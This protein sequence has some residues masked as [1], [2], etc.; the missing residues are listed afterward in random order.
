MSIDQNDTG[1]IDLLNSP[2]GPVLPTVTVDGWGTGTVAE[3]EHHLK[4]LKDERDA[5]WD[6]VRALE[7]KLDPLQALADAIAALPVFVEMAGDLDDLRDRV[8]SLEQ[9]AEEIPTAEDVAQEIEYRGTIE[10]AV[11]TILDDRAV[12]IP[13]NN[14][15][16]LARAVADMLSV[17]VEIDDITVE[18]SATVSV[19]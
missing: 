19:S 11:E 5:G 18:A 16:E 15:E 9:T 2:V 3:L 6:R 4:H 7:N 13:A 1:T 10:S 8:D 14:L 12:S 17:E